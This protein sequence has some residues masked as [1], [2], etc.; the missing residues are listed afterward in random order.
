[1]NDSRISTPIPRDLPPLFRDLE[2]VAAAE[3][4]DICRREGLPESMP[5]NDYTITADACWR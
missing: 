5:E 1:M 3:I 2:R 4:K